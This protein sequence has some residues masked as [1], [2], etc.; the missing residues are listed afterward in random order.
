MKNALS[1]GMVI[2]SIGIYTG[3]YDIKKHYLNKDYTAISLA[4]AV[5]GL[6]ILLL[7]L[8]NNESKRI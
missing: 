8:F 1:A 6:N 3:L 7:Y 2:T 5:T 4:S